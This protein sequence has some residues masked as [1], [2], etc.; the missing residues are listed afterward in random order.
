M[1]PWRYCRKYCDHFECILVESAE[2]CMMTEVLQAAV[3]EAA[4]AVVVVVVVASAAAVA[5]RIG[6]GLLSSSSSPSLSLLQLHRCRCCC[7]S[8]S[9]QGFGYGIPELQAKLQCPALNFG[10]KPLSLNLADPSRFAHPFV[11]PGL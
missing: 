7:C 4:A 10:Y 9:V 1:W 5:K 8:S 3:A 11:A 6:C 2:E